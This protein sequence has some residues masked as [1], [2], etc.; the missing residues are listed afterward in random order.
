MPLPAEIRSKRITR[1]WT[2]SQLASAA[3]VSQALIS[4][5]ETG[6]VAP[7][8]AVLAALGFAGSTPPPREERFK[9]PPPWHPQFEP[10]HLLVHVR[11]WQR[12]TASGDGVITAPLPQG[13]FLV[14]AVDVTGHGAEHVPK[15]TYLEGWVRGWSRTLSVV[16]RLES[17]IEEIE[18]EMR[19]AQL[20]AA[21]Y[22]GII[23]PVTG[24]SCAV[25]Y[26]GAARRFPAPLL[27]TGAPPQTLP[28]VGRGAEAVR[29]EIHPPWRIA[30]ATDGLLRRL[31]NG[32]EQRGKE[33]LL[34]WQRSHSRD[35]PPD[36]RLETSQP[37]ADDE[38]YV[39]VTWQRWDG[40]ET[41][42]IRDNA[43][44]HR[45]MRILESTISLQPR[46][47]SALLIAVAEALH[48]V[49]RH[50]YGEQG[51]GMVRVSWRDEAERVRVEVEDN[52]VGQI[53]L[54][55]GGGYRVMR[56]HASVDV[57]R[58]FPRG[59]VVSLSKEKESR[60]DQ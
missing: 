17:V 36:A 33:Q 46:E 32:D 12:P 27:L 25:S 44:R 53:L 30:I 40:V 59:L 2:Q 16:P 19:A 54:T 35:M 11:R 28:A 3:G 57:R 55:E 51:S 29:H 1:G 22:M 39:D 10:T 41:L 49:L 56:C 48:N 21:W 6:H 13:S 45:L 26:Q 8:P 18:S 50:A 34:A 37:V 20:N 9:A 31:G 4:R 5:I 15:V 52:G 47:S 24:S 23:S 43:Q 58:A 14:L 7:S 60:N 42:D 38:L